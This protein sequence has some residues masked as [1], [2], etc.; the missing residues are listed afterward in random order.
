MKIGVLVGVNTGVLTGYE[1]AICEVKGYIEVTADDSV[2]V[3]VDVPGEV[4]KEELNEEDSNELDW[5]FTIEEVVVDVKS[6]VLSE[7]EL[8]E[9]TTVKLEV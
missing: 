6:G 5:L 4:N 3:A 1:E 8:G 2:A 7:E 9:G